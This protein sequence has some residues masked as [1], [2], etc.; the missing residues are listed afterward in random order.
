M[1]VLVHYS[2][3]LVDSLLNL[4]KSSKPMRLEGANSN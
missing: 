3:S 4:G 2:P 1:L